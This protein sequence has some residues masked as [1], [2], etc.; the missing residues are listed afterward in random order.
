MK[1]ISSYAIV[2]DAKGR[3][4]KARQSG[5]L[6]YTAVKFNPGLHLKE[7][8]ENLIRL[9]NDLGLN[10]GRKKEKKL[11]HFGILIANL[12]DQKMNPVR[13]SRNIKSWVKTMYQPLSHS[14]IKAMDSLHK[15][16]YLEMIKGRYF[17]NQRYQTRI[18]ANESLL[19]LFPIGNQI[20]GYYPVEFV[21]LWQKEK[22]QYIHP[23]TKR[24]RTRKI[25]HLIDYKDKKSNVRETEKIRRLRKKLIKAFEV[26]EKANISYVE[27]GEVRRLNVAMIAKFTNDFRHGGRLYSEGRS[28]FQGYSEDERK[29]ITIK[30]N[31]TI[32]LDYSGLHPYL[33]YAGEGIQYDVDPYTVVDDRP[34]LRPFLKMILLYMINN[35]SFNEA[36]R[37]ANDWLVHPKKKEEQ[38]CKRIFALGVDKA[39]PLMDK[40]L[41]EHSRISKYL[42]VSSKTGLRLMNKDA[43]IA[44][45]VIYH[46]VK[47]EIPILSMHDSFLI[48]RKYKDELEQV[49]KEKYYKNTGFTII[50]K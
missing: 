38:I 13:I 28:Y 31:P 1:R 48:E 6:F 9:F 39:G 45:D 26:N 47:Q 33:L 23:E 16:N 8:H 32:E 34:E 15:K 17:E 18:W 35:S 36:Q 19:R 29:N 27:D 37:V 14:I 42:C 46:F 30:G 22:Q 43:E 2:E 25:K 7:N 5:S 3:R 40:F 21:E 12:I 41:V 10:E 11:K 50:V 4:G 24:R 49:M 20:V 44:V